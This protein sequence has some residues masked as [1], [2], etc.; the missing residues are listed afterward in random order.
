MMVALV[1]NATDLL[2]DGLD[3]L[4]SLDSRLYQ[5]IGDTSPGAAQRSHRWRLVAH[6]GAAR[7]LN[8]TRSVPSSN[9]AFVTSRRCSASGKRNDLR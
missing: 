9:C 7:S 1:G 3:G 4:E 2:D 5:V 8:V 6:L